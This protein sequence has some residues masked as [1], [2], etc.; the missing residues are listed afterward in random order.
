MRIPASY[1]K[2][3]LSL[4]SSAAERK[5]SGTVSDARIERP[6]APIAERDLGASGRETSRQP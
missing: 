6:L 2:S 4:R 5:D 3:L 1:P